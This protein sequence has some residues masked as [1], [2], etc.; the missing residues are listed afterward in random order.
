MVLGPKE[1]NSTAYNWPATEADQLGR[2]MVQPTRP[3]GWEG[4]IPEHKCSMK[5]LNHR[6]KGKYKQKN[7]MRL[8]TE[9]M[10]KFSLRDFCEIWWTLDIGFNTILLSRKYL[11]VN[12]VC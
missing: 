3:Q 12:M 5:D 6:E 10:S 2:T 9:L 4:L 7:W 1:D 8:K 11:L